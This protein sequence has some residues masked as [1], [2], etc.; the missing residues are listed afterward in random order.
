MHVRRGSSL[1]WN[2]AEHYVREMWQWQT[3]VTVARLVRSEGLVRRPVQIRFYHIHI[4]H[5]YITYDIYICM[6]IFICLPGKWKFYA[7]CNIR[8]GYV[9]RTLLPI[10]E[11]IQPISNLT[12]K[13]QI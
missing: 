7:I 8:H 4:L 2:Q 5:M 3:E 12:Q 6:Y 9:V 11:T 10:A 13:H 1:L